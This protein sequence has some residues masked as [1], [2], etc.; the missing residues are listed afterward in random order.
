MSQGLK[1]GPHIVN[2]LLVFFLQDY[3]YSFVI[4]KPILPGHIL[5][6]PQRPVAKFRDLTTPEMFE[7]SL[8][9]QALTRMVKQAANTDSCTISIQEGQGMG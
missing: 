4:A 8:S 9:I 6:C 7:L 1:L 2:P 5:I 3:T